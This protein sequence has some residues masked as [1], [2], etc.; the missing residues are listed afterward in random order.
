MGVNDMYGIVMHDYMRDYLEK[1]FVI[2][3]GN[4]K[5]EAVT[6]AWNTLKS[7]MENDI[8]YLRFDCDDNR[9]TKT[10]FIKGILDNEQ[11]KDGVYFSDPCSL[12]IK[13][14]KIPNR[15]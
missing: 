10:S 12:Y 9:V 2:A 3:Y 13:L 4:T 8:E 1:E 6:N 7:D 15:V 14:F 11:S 5:E